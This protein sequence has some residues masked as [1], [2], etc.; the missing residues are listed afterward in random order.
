MVNH[1]TGGLLWISLA[2]K[3]HFL[4][5]SYLLLLLVARCILELLN[6]NVT[7]CVYFFGEFLGI[8]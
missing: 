1:D 6:L 8:T 3:L 4:G 7:P 2:D 5:S